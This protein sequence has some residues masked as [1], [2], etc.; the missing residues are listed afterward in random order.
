MTSISV[1]VPEEGWDEANDEFYK[2]T[3]TNIQ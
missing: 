3:A 2:K 1:Y